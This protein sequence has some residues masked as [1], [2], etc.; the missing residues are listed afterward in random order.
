M[1]SVL[2]SMFFRQPR[3][4]GLGRLIDSPPTVRGG[5]CQIITRDSIVVRRMPSHIS[6]MVPSTVHSGP[7][8]LIKSR[9][10][11]LRVRLA[12]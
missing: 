2:L 5:F 3:V 1:Q 6:N 10:F 11:T 12:L 4:Q 7:P 9:T 8:D